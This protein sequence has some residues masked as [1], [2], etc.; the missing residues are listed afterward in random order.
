MIF[1]E[2]LGDVVLVGCVIIDGIV[3]IYLNNC[4]IMD[5]LIDDDLS[6]CVVLEGVVFGVYI[7]WVDQVGVDGDVVSWIEILFLCEEIEVVVVVLVDQ[8]EQD[9]FVVVQCI[10]ECGNMLWVIVCEK[11]GEGIFYVY[12]YEVNKDQIC[13][14]DLIYLGQ[15]F[16]LLE[17]DGV[18][19]NQV[20]EF[21]V[22]LCQ[23]L[24]VIVNGF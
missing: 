7:F 3:W 5:G 12:V 20:L 23:G 18:L 24:L 13:D 22:I 1:Y 16:V 9:D 19:G 21:L 17:L 14:F 10:V 4:L 11:Y 15:I 6:W 2:L 8:I